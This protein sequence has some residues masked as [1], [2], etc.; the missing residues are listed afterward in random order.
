MR[1]AT[2]AGHRRVVLDLARVTFVDSS[3][4]GAIISAMK[5]LG[6]DRRIQDA[7]A[8]LGPAAGMML[9]SAG[10]RAGG[11]TSEAASR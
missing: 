9:S 11:P 7:L 2:E 5:H 8:A 1:S 6:G 10:G 3:G 4:L